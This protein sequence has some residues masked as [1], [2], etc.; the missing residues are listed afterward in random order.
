MEAPEVRWLELVRKYPSPHNGQPMVLNRISDNSYEILFETNRGLGATPISNLFSFVTIGVFFEYVE[1]C[2]TALGHSV[3]SEIAL[4]EL[5]GMSQPNTELLCGKVVIGWNQAAPNTELEEAIEFRQTSRKKYVSG[6]SKKEKDGA[7]NLVSYTGQTLTFLNRQQA[8]QTAWLNQRAVFDDMFNNEVRE[9]LRNWLRT[10]HKEKI[11][12][13]DGLSYDCMEMSGAALRF[14]LNHHKVLRWPIVAP[15]L[16]QYYLRTMKDA[17]S[18]GYIS[19][20][21]VTEKDAYEVGRSIMKVW[22]E[23]SKHKAYLHPF[24]TIVSNQ[25]AH[26]DFLKVI[27]KTDETRNNYVTFIFRAGRSTKPVESERLLMRHLIKG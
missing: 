7:V 18:I 20:S 22:L 25:Q 13:K 3:H 4:P 15:L 21:F 8:H 5:E 19:S 17:S 6:I 24:G 1:S 2:A 9:E 12:K 10:T 11:T 26:S 27:G 14:S 16:R 23:L